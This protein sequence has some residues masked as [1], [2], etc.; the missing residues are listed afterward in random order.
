MSIVD[1]DNALLG[2]AGR[3]GSYPDKIN[4]SLEASVGSVGATPDLWK[5]KFDGEA[6]AEG[7]NADRYLKYLQSLG[8]TSNNLGQAKKEVLALGIAPS[9]P[10]SAGGGIL[11]FAH[12]DLITAHTMDSISG[13]TLV[14]ESPNG[15][16]GVITG[17]TPV[18]GLLDNA[19]SFNGTSDSVGLVAPD[20]DDSMVFSIWVYFQKNATG[21]TQVVIGQSRDNFQSTR[22]LFVNTSGQLVFFSRNAGGGYEQTPNS[23]VYADN[24]WHHAYCEQDG[25]NLKLVINGS[26]T[27]THVMPSAATTWVNDLTMGR[28]NAGNPGP[29][30][31]GGLVDQFRR[32][33]RPLIE[34]E[35]QALY[36]E[37]V[38]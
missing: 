26:E 33:N 9:E 29:L 34:E 6:I 18:A 2:A 31:Y 8:A 4:Q 22:A 13:T 17:A 20:T 15:N 35:I 16:D 24:T 21:T 5:K 14:D 23:S 37:G 3:T 19:L 38:A 12:P 1:D 30:W 27:L 32:F 7:S 28:N 10:P 11:G 25:V 36:S